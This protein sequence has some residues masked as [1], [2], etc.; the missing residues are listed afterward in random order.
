VRNA[1]AITAPGGE[2]VVYEVTDGGVRADV[3]FD[4][5][6]VWLTQQQMAELFGRDNSVVTRHVRNAFHEGEPDPEA[7]SENLHWFDPKADGYRVKLPCGTWFR[8]RVARTLVR[9]YTPK[10]TD[11]P[12]AARGG[13]AKPWRR[14]HG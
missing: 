11:L 8:Q 9:R 7:I 4:R 6:T 1:S 2:V 10:T 12:N 14:I 3:R 13:G 5:E